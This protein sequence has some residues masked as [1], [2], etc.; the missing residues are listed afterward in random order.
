MYSTLLF[1]LDGTLSD[2][3]LGI[4]QSINHALI[5]HGFDARSL[6]DLAECVGP[7]L[8]QSFKRLTGV[9]ETD[10]LVSMVAK[11]RE[12]YLDIGF[13][14]N[15]LYPGV[16]DA[17]EHLKTSGAHIALCTS[18]PEP[19]TRL[20]LEHF[21]ITSYFRFI[22]CGDVG[23]EKWQQLQALR[24]DGVIDHNAIMVGDRSFDVEA[25][26]RNSLFTGAVTWGYGS[27]AE[28][29]EAGPD[30][31]FHSPSEWLG[32]LESNSPNGRES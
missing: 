13:Q 2:P 3:L 5:A 1:D 8:D 18:K 16:T 20:I 6:P 24:A 25:G 17:L 28:L 11:Y 26:R 19:G 29:T 21:N 10:L 27:S 4:G 30:R 23:I 15:T 22:S 14:E 31:W 7:P 32:L 12:R 9:E